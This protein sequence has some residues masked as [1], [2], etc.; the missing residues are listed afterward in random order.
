[1]AALIKFSLKLDLNIL[2]TGLEP[3]LQHNLGSE[4][5]GDSG[6]FYM[7]CFPGTI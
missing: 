3:F 4:H 1:M 6:D 2:K 5:Q 7:L